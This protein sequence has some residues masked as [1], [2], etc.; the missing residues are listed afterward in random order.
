MG[1]GLSAAP[2]EPRTV[3]Y[4]R[5]ASRFLDVAM[6]AKRYRGSQTGADPKE[7]LSVPG[8]LRFI[9]WAKSVFKGGRAI[10]REL[11]DGEVAQVLDWRKSMTYAITGM[12]RLVCEVPLRPLPVRVPMA[13]IIGAMV[14]MNQELNGGRPLVG[15]FHGS[16]SQGTESWEPPQDSGEGPGEVR[17]GP[18]GIQE[19]EAYGHYVDP[20]TLWRS[21]WRRARTM[22]RSTRPCGHT[23]DRVLEWKRP[24]NG[25]VC[26]CT[27]VGSEGCVG[28]F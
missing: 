1:A 5:R 25:Y 6:K 3:V 2:R 24:V 22:L 16:G 14:W 26:F 9:V 11:D 27:F 10:K 19:T 7:L 15:E 4:Q 18:P 20:G 23:A 21:R 13:M 28:R 17:G 8:D 12:R